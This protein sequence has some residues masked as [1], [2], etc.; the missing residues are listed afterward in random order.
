M[1]S[2]AMIGG[3]RKGGKGKSKMKQKNPKKPDISEMEIP[4]IP[5]ATPGEPVAGPPAA[6]PPAEAHAAQIQRPSLP[7]APSMPDIEI[8]E[9]DEIMCL[10]FHII[11][12]VIIYLVW[13][14]DIV[15]IIFKV[16][17]SRFA[18]PVGMIN[19]IN[20]LSMCT[21]VS[22]E[23]VDRTKIEQD[24]EGAGASGFV[25]AKHEQRLADGPISA[26][27][28]NEVIISELTETL[29]E[30]IQTTQ[31]TVGASQEIERPSDI[32]FPKNEKNAQR[33]VYVVDRAKEEVYMGEIPADPNQACSNGKPKFRP[34]TEQYI[35]PGNAYN[36]V[37][38]TGI[39]KN[40]LPEQISPV[41][42]C[43]PNFEQKQ[44]IS[45]Y[46]LNISEEEL[47][48][49]I[50]NKVDMFTKTK[51]QTVG[52]ITNCDPKI[53]QKVKNKTSVTMENLI[54]NQIKQLITQNVDVSQKLKIHDRYGMCSPPYP[55]KCKKLDSDEIF[56]Q[57]NNKCDCDELNGARG[58]EWVLSVTKYCDNPSKC[59]CYNCC[60]SNQRWIKQ[61]IT[62]DTVAKNIASASQEVAMK[63]NIKTK[64]ENTVVYI[65][66]VPARIVMFSLL[67]NVAAIY[68]LYN[69][70]KYVKKLF[71]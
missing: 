55:F 40:V 13:W 68:V 9:P 7:S 18:W 19:E 8:P 71:F 53:S 70:V 65:Q 63:N 44:T 1:K 50:S 34:G 57:K 48:K 38:P 66:D 3:K 36:I 20:P 35:C 61:N 64:V 58:G 51:L 12:A 37:L 67:W 4:D 22:K 15:K 14:D 52:E 41:Y 32:I 10:V 33:Q 42:G 16:Q 46:S 43:N 24:S 31:Q 39:K 47:T 23:L 45:S 49:K 29:N 11:I 6:G 54:Q 17:C 27:T 62:I 30:F 25:H 5:Q 69:I 59:R 26:E 60:Q 2:L 28:S 56:P 21:S